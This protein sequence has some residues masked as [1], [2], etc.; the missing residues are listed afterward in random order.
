MTYTNV[1]SD[2]GRLAY[3][4]Y[5]NSSTGVLC[6]HSNSSCREA[7]R[8]LGRSELSNRFRVVCVDLPGHG[9]SSDAVDGSEYYTIPGMARLLNQFIKNHE[10][11]FSAIVG[12]SLGGHI[13]LEM[14]A[15]NSSIGKL[16]L[17]G[18]P[19]CGPGI[20]N[21]EGA[22]L[23]VEHMELTGKNYF[24]DEEAELYARHTVG[25][26]LGKHPELLAAVRRA[27]GACR[28]TMA[29]HWSSPSDAKTQSGFVAQWAG[30][31]AII[32]GQEDSFVAKP[33]LE[34][35]PVNNL[36]CDRIHYIE[37]AGHAPMLDNSAEYNKLLN[38]FLA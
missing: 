36:W 14:A 38:I 31:L 37:A 28:A 30:E 24:S 6:L 17:S 11:N 4:E 8:A 9:E 26:N 1:N 29:R 32:Q 20:E 19:P 2:F 3:T 25:K 10:C 22:F 23:P 33:Y 13:A 15:T 35:L 21:M 34:S 7:F 18:T 16:V 12:W 27:D 5:G